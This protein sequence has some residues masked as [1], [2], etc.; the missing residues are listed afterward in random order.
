M[1]QA[2][3]SFSVS[4]TLLFPV[5]FPSIL[6]VFFVFYMCTMLMVLMF[7][8]ILMYVCF[9]SDAGV[10]VDDSRQLV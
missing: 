2:M 5:F 8:W 1:S 7:L 3:F 4:G 10:L 6:Y 9:L